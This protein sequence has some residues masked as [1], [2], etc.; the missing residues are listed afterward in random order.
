MAKQDK[1][2]E[3][4]ALEWV[5]WNCRVAFRGFGSTER[6]RD[7]VV[8]LVFLKFAGEKFENRRQEII[9]EHPDIEILREMSA[10][11]NAENVYYLKETARWDYIVKNASSNDKQLLLIQLW[12]ILKRITLLLKELCPKIYIQL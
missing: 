7:A 4:I 5:L 6:N 3:E 12:R 9:E 8:G 10:S 2:N 11:Y 1:K